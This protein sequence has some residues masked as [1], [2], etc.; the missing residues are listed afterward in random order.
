MAG[1]VQAMDARPEG[2][3]A[4]ATAD[5]SSLDKQSLSWLGSTRGEPTGTIASANGG[6]S[7]FAIDGVSPSFRL[8]RLVSPPAGGSPAV[9]N[10]DNGA[11]AICM[12]PTQNRKRPNASIRCL[13][14]FASVPLVLRKRKECQKAL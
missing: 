1:F 8:S 7:D 9:A 11:G 14:R 5:R 3:A 2:G 13:L 10:G 12:S 6:G 4:M